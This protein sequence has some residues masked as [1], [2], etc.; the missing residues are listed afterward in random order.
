MVAIVLAGSNAPTFV[1]PQLW[2]GI[3]SWWEAP[4]GDIWNLLDGSSGI[5]LRPGTRGFGNPE[6]DSPQEELPGIPG[7]RFRGTRPKAREVFWV[8]GIYEPRESGDILDLDAK[9][10][11][12]MDPDAFGWWYVKTPKGQVRRLQVRFRGEG[13]TAWDLLPG[14]SEWMLYGLYLEATERP[15]WEGAAITAAFPPPKESSFF[16]ETGGPPF[17]ISRGSSTET[18]TLTNPGQAD[19]WPV[20]RIDGPFTSTS[21]GTVGYTTTIPINIPA[22]RTLIIDTDPRTGTA[23]LGTWNNT[24]QSLNPGATNVMRQIGV[25]NFAP[26][27]KG[28]D[29]PLTLTAVGTGL[30]SATIT[31]L[32]RR[33]W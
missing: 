12:T 21:V 15:L 33:A 16:G 3:E 22:G 17:M 10:W 4:N 20:W 32:Y 30:I 23:Y 29:V 26:I 14:T 1:P 7:A 31:P 2:S 25:T 18:A 5:S 19:A 13:D 28:K 24:T 8:L 27:P 9:F 11:D 6:Y